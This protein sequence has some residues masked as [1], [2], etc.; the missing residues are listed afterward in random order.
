MKKELLSITLCFVL[1]FLSLSGCF[2]EKK[3]TTDKTVDDTTEDDEINVTGTIQKL[4]N[5]A[6]EGDI[7]TIPSGTYYE[8]IIINK[9][10]TL[11][12]ENKEI[13]ILDGNEEDSVITINANNVKISDFTIQN[14]GNSFEEW[15]GAGIKV[16]SDNCNISNNIIS[17]HDWFYGIYLNGSHNSH[18]IDNTIT[19]NYQGI[20]VDKSE[21]ITIEKNSVSSNIYKYGIELSYSDNNI[22]RDN[23][24]FS[25]NDA[26]LYL[27][28]SSDNIIQ[29]N[30]FTDNNVG[31]DLTKNCYRNEIKDNEITS[32]SDTGIAL[33]IVSNNEITGN[34]IDDCHSNGILIFNS[35]DNTV[36]S[37]SISNCYYGI[38]MDDSSENNIVTDNNISSNDIFG[39]SIDDESNSNTIYNN[40]FIE[41]S[42]SAHDRSNNQ[43]DNGAVGNY[44]DDYT[45]SD[46][47]SDGIGETAY[48]IEGGDNKD[49]YPLIKPVSGE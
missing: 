42:R 49:N 47:N 26:G 40:N 38:N 10:I 4:I 46:A 28:Y 2:E 19:N 7:L 13:T 14:S 32:G 5:N 41:N 22:V 3:D 20:L 6:S 45:G 30:I 23:N 48:D 44:W 16:F 39:I 27:E 35:T 8:N 17:N 36:L 12:G 1:I 9:S 24:I 33:A 11:K 25:I 31:I 43:W 15:L 37:N 34:K 18:I 21:Y 29:K